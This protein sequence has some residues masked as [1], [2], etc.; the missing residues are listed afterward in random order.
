V[1]HP[2]IAASKDE[3]TVST[4]VSYRVSS[5]AGGGRKK[6]ATEKGKIE[7]PI[8]LSFIFYMNTQ[9]FDI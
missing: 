2:K 1:S 8:E 7:F 3:Y 9:H 6:R 4:S 5:S